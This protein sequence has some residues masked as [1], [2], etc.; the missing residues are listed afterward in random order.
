MRSDF[1]YENTVIE[2]QY[3]FTQKIAQSAKSARD[4]EYN[5]SMSSLMIMFHSKRL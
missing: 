2:I 3:L 4:K 1:H 5:N